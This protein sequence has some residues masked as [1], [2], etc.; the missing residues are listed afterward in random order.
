MRQKT[1]YINEGDSGDMA[2][3]NGSAEEE[4]NNAASNEEQSNADAPDGKGQ[5]PRG[6]DV[7][8]DQGQ[9]QFNE[10]TLQMQHRSRPCE[11]EAT[12]MDC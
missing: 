10:E 12:A 2:I 6:E 9:H 1:G 3:A 11:A 8:E 4:Q 7:V 5:S